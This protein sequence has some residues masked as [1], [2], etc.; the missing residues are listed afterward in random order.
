MKLIVT[1][2][3]IAMAAMAPIGASAAEYAVTKSRIE[4]LKA[5]F[6][7]V[8]STHSPVARARIGGVVGAVSVIEG[9]AVKEG[10]I[11]A[12]VG[13]RKL[14]LE[15][16]GY[17]ARIQSAAAERSKAQ[18]DLNRNRELLAQGVIAKARMDDISTRMQVA[19]QAYAAARAERDVLAQRSKEGQVLAP[20]AGRVLKVHVVDGAVV[21]PGDPIATIAQDDY[22]LRMR[23]PERQARFIRI[24]STVKV[25]PRGMENADP[26]ALREG[27]VVQ[28]YPEMDRGRVVA[29]I[30]VEGLGDFFVGERAIVHVATGSREAYVLPEDA[31][32][33]R[34]G[35]TYVTLKSGAQVVIQT[36]RSTPDGIE[37]L[38]GLE[39][40]DVVVTP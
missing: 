13:D 6:A 26:K 19:D 38:S 23:M 10:E 18:A 32:R 11:L 7:T 25:G 28:V 14:S 17:D 1:L 39:D 4:D 29:D 27:Q 9:S 35:V 24:G 15:M 30:R 33:R 31:I 22:V 2:G 5:G 3:L 21:M 34:Y 20:G 8:E 12:V 37:V 16:G 36:G 40:G